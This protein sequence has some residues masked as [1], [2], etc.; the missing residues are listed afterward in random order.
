MGGGKVN[1][2]SMTII[3]FP[4]LLVPPKLDGQ[5]LP[6]LSTQLLRP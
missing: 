3:Q 6:T 5:K 2:T 4:I 1:K